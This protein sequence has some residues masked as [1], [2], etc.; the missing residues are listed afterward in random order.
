[1]DCPVKKGDI[2]RLTTDKAYLEKGNSGTVYINYEDILKIVQSDDRIF[3]SDGTISLIVSEIHGSNIITIIECDGTLKSLTSVFLPN[4]RPQLPSLS[5]QDKVNISNAMGI[6]IHYI[7]AGRVRNAADVQAIRDY[8]GTAGEK[9][10]IV[11]R[12]DGYQA[13]Q[14]LDE[15]MDVSDVI[16]IN[17]FYLGVEIPHEKVFIAQKSIIAR[18]VDEFIVIPFKSG[19]NYCFI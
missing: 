12:I 15:I 19:M 2:L 6:G 9:I 18:C 5:D 10:R 8:V 13:I 11:A 7:L 14:N 1:M 16:F 4:I 3:V 17:R